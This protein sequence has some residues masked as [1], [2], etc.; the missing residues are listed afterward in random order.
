MYEYSKCFWHNIIHLS[1]NENKHWCWKDTFREGRHQEKISNSMA[2]LM[3]ALIK[4]KTHILF[5][6]A[7]LLMCT[8]FQCGLAVAGR[9]VGTKVAFGI[10]CF[11]YS[12]CMDSYQYTVDYR[13][14]ECKILGYDGQKGYC[15]KENRGVCCCA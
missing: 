9:D 15:K 6:V 4:N 5:C 12:V 11:T 14:K 3:M 1:T 13:N 10:Q 8:T 7:L 2:V